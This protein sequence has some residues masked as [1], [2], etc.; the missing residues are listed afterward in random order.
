MISKT[1]KVFIFAMISSI[2]FLGG[3]SSKVITTTIDEFG[4]TVKTVSTA[5]VERDKVY[6]EQR[7]QRDSNTSAMYELQGVNT[8][9]G[10]YRVEKGD[11]VVVVI[12]PKKQTL[13]APHRYQQEILNAP[14]DHRAYDS[15][16]NLVNKAT[17]GF[18]GWLVNDNSKAQMERNSTEYRGDYVTYQNSNNPTSSSSEIAP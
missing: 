1:G 13:R 5:A 15:F 6:S 18:A 10:E 4:N 11:V 8:E 12:G 16:D 3:C 17:L 9:W 14:P 7:K 2:L